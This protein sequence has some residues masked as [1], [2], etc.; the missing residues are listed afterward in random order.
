VGMVAMTGVAGV[1]CVAVGVE[2]C[3]HFDSFA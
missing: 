1:T 2:N 3:A